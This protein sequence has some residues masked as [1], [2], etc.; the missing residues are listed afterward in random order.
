MP[1]AS[2]RKRKATGPTPTP[3]SK[4]PR[5]SASTQALCDLTAAFNR[6]AIILEKA[7][8]NNVPTSSTRKTD[9][10]KAVMKL[11]NKLEKDWLTKR[12]MALLLD[13]FEKEPFAVES[14]QLVHEDD[15]LCR[16]W[17]YIKLNILPD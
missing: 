4:K 3:T 6:V 11:A 7:F 13:I 9:S 12:Q 14:Y 1:A 15:E 5:V 16:E 10:V 2:G 8:E 17:I